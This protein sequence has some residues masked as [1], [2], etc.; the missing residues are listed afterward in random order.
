MLR[1]CVYWIAAVCCFGLLGCGDDVETLRVDSPAATGPFAVG[2]TRLTVVDDGRAGRTLAVEVWYP[3]EPGRE[4]GLERTNYD[5]AMGIGLD[6]EVAFEDA[7]VSIR[8]AQPVLIFSHGYRGISLQSIDF[9]EFLASH[10]FI[11]AS[12]EH[13]GNAQFSDGDDFD[14]AA[15]NR[16]PDVRAVFDDLVDRSRD[17]A[18]PFHRR[19]DQSRYGVVG[20]SFGGMT[21][22]GAAAGWAGAS[23][24]PRVRAIVPIS[25]VIDR[26]L[27][28]DER[29]GPNA[30]FTAAQLAS[31]RVP[32]L[33]IGGSEDVDVFP[34]NNRIAFDQLINA[35]AAYRLE[36]VGA[37][38][39]HFASVCTFGELLI[40]LGLT[41]D[42]WPAVGAQDLIA[43]FNST[44][45]GDVLPV[46]EVVRLQNFYA[47]AF[48]KRH[49][50]G[51]IAYD[52]YLSR[53]QAE[54]EPSVDL[55]TR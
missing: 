16:V 33:L 44:C 18:S 4:V 17:P 51:E 35:P 26:E 55:A 42:R 12:P 8:S 29:S 21:A 10:G 37:N 32:V 6:S 48:F 39:N 22:I 43:P 9:V 5:L 46:D 36:I 24:D 14:T 28:R 19:I 7:P 45:T 1:A 47:T 30:G 49:L 52:R 20:H 27:Q 34:E 2:H 54:A 23:A 25:A 15:A 3:I 11:V 40:G 50:L 13:T 31:I 41:P 38:H 53:E